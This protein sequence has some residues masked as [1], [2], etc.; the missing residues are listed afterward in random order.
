[1]FYYL[2]TKRTLHDSD[3]DGLISSDLVELTA[4]RHQE[5]KDGVE[6]GGRLEHD[7]NGVP[8]L[9]QP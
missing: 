1:M 8:F 9:V 6:A 2:P 3:A 7:V 5:L 4:A